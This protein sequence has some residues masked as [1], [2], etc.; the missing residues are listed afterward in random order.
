MEVTSE[1]DE[2]EDVR[3]Q[4]LGGG[5]GGGGWRGAEQECPWEGLG[6]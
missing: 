4:G 1:Q 3:E 2:Q 6:A 5:G